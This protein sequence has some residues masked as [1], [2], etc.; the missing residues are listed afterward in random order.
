[1]TTN[2]VVD[3]LLAVSKSA[4]IVPLLD[5]ATFRSLRTARRSR[6]RSAFLAVLAPFRGSHL[7]AT[8]QS[9]ERNHAYSQIG[10]SVSIS[11]STNK[12]C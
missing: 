9:V 3:T 6:L 1:M 12:E 8:A 2:A 5:G 10:A 11:C 4:A 7:S